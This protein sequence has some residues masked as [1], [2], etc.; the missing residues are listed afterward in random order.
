MA[1]VG[2]YLFRDLLVSVLGF[3]VIFPALGPLAV[4]VVGGLAVALLFVALAAIV[5]AL[6]ISRQE[7]AVSMRE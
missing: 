1:A 6:R 3:P 4:P 7:P 5:P 2:V